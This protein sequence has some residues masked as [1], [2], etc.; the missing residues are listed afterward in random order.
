MAIDKWLSHL[1]MEK[2]SS[3]ATR[4]E[5]NLRLLVAHANLLDSIHEV[6][7]VQKGEEEQNSWFIECVKAA[8]EHGCILA[9][10][11]DAADDSLDQGD[12]CIA[13]YGAKVSCVEVKEYDVEDDDNGKY[14]LSAIA[15]QKEV[16]AIEALP[17][18]RSKYPTRNDV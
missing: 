11:R 13:D 17:E 15:Y 16:P 3:E 8:T 18:L 14:I 1:I 10:D 7:E 2:L 6:K 12:Y 4:P 9:I 5:Q